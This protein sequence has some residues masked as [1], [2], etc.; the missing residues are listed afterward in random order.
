[1]KNSVIMVTTAILTILLLS[2]I[3]L[4]FGNITEID[5][6]ST[7][8]AVSTSS[9]MNNTNSLTNFVNTNS[10]ILDNTNNITANN[11]NATTN[12]FSNFANYTNTNTML[13]EDPSP[14]DSNIITNSIV[15]YTSNTSSSG[16]DASNIINIFMIVVGIVIILLGFAILVRSK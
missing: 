2:T 13:N 8:N 1:M 5:Q 4:A 9:L 16:L 15:P 3:V 7:S 6:T 11:M 14:V 10:S 12:D